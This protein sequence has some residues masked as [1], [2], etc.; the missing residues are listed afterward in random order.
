MEV[1]V[2]A[3]N[4]FFCWSYI[5]RQ[6][7]IP[8]ERTLLLDALQVVTSVKEHDVSQVPPLLFLLAVRQSQ[9]IDQST[10]KPWICKRSLLAMKWDMRQASLR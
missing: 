5:L 1:K 10:I 3:Y 8:K 2:I 6:K 9:S 7:L 4:T